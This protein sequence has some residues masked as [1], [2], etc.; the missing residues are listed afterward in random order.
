MAKRTTIYDIANRLGLSTATVNRALSGKP[1]I[2]EET[3]AL[4]LRTAEEMNYRPNSLAHS[5]ARRTLR[6]AIVCLTSFPEFHSCF[7]DGVRDAALELA[8]YNIHVDYF[9]YNDGAT[10]T[11]QADSYLTESLRRISEEG[12]DGV[13][14]LARPDDGFRLLR[15]K[16]VCVGAAVNDIGP[17]DRD[18]CIAHDG[19][20]AGRVAAELIYHWMLD[21]ERP[22]A[23]A[24]GNQEITIHINTVQGFRSQLTRTPLNLKSV[25]Y[26]YDN[27]DIAFHETEALLRSCPDLGA[28]Y[29]NSFNSRG[30]IRAVQASGRNGIVLVTSD[31]CRA[32]AEDIEAGTV[33]ASIFQNQYEQGRRGLHALYQRLNG[34]TAEAESIVISPQ[35]ILSGNLSIYFPG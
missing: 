7:L 26:N 3:R 21:R 32:L 33:A 1:R 18:F 10:N 22:V 5:L 2:S 28:I 19:F 27:E 8:D 15:K 30:V 20:A 29:V 9:V 4:I 16:G 31:I 17:E 25:Y 35:I 13:L 6:I 11:P 34:H 24:S 14:A 12:Y 23:I